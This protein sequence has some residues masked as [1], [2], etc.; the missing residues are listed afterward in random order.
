[1]YKELE[2]RIE[3]HKTQL[4]YLNLQEQFIALQREKISSLLE[5]TQREQKETQ[6]KK[7]E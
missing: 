6:E 3:I 2:L 4:A 1:M 5:E 7:E